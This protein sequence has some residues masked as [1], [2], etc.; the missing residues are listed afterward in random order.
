MRSSDSSRQTRM[1]KNWQNSRMTGN[2]YDDDSRHSEWIHSHWLESEVKS[3]STERKDRKWW[4]INGFSLSNIYL[5]LLL[6]HR[7]SLLSTISFFTSPLL[8]HTFMATIMCFVSLVPDM[9]LGRIHGISY[10]TVI[11]FVLAYKLYVYRYYI[12]QLYLFNDMLHRC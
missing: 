4:K 1:R 8:F 7:F 6:L 10:I 2:H 5:L 11:S 12:V 9:T 3:V